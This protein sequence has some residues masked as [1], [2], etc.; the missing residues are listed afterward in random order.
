MTSV[1]EAAEPADWVTLDQASLL[2]LFLD[3]GVAVFELA[4]QF[5]PRHVANMKMLAASGYWDGL[6]IVRSQDNYVVQWGDPAAG[7]DAARSTG[8]AAASLEPEFLRLR[9]GLA[10]IPI[11]SRDPYADQVG[12]VQ[13]FPAASDGSRAWLAHCYGMLGVGRGNAPNSGSGAELYVVIG[14]A[15]R[16]LDRNVTL[17]GRAVHGMEHLSALPRGSGALGFYEDEGELVPVARI[18]IGSDLNPAEQITLRRLRTDTE[19]FSRLVDARRSRREAWFVD[20]T[21]HIGLCNVPLPV[22]VGD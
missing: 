10:L 11:D 3:S 6:S 7:T 8:E 19:T 9:D 15:P 21:G 18:R 1:L 4:P 22:R 13:G 17:V 14:H 20:E 5:A 2:Y 12:F 16:H